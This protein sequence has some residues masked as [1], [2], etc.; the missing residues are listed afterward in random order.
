MKILKSIKA[1]YLWQNPIWYVLL[2][3]VSYWFP[4][5]FWKHVTLVLSRQYLPTLLMKI[6]Y[7]HHYHSLKLLGNALLDLKVFLI[8]WFDQSGIYIKMQM[9]SDM[10]VALEK[11]NSC[12]LLFACLWGKAERNSWKLG[13]TTHSLAKKDQMLVFRHIDKCFII[14]LI[15]SE[16]FLVKNCIFSRWISQD[17]S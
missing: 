5:K 10:E 17:M 12:M 6:A 11:C 16:R 4:N 3:S 9:Q 1:D 2:F 13:A 7:T 14:L 8:A 15:Y